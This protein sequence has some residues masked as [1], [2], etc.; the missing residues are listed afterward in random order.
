M[1]WRRAIRSSSLHLL[2]VKSLNRYVCCT[3]HD[4]R[5]TIF[6]HRSHRASMSRLSYARAR[7]RRF[8]VAGPTRRVPTIVRPTSCRK[9]NMAR[10][11]RRLCRGYLKIA[12][13]RGCFPQAKLKPGERGE[14]GAAPGV[15]YGEASCGEPRDL[16]Q[17]LI[18]TKTVP[19][20]MRPADA[21]LPEPVCRRAQRPAAQSN[22]PA[23]RKAAADF[24]Q[25]FQIGQTAATRA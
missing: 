25:P 17:E 22:A 6:S 20:G 5:I 16:P 9:G 23:F 3:I 8:P 24:A 1:R 13:A 15:Q 7:L 4:S 11:D 18:S 10:V 12:C 19:C 2:I 14:I 21:Y